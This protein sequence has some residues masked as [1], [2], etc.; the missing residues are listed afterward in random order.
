VANTTKVEILAMSVDVG[1]G[2]HGVELIMLLEP[3]FIGE[4]V[5]TKGGHS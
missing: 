4:Q 1:G 2:K 3:H 5:M